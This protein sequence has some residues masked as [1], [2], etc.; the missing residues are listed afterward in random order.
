MNKS[1]PKELTDVIIT[2]F[3]KVYNE[4]GYG[5]WENVYKNALYFALTDEGVKCETEKPIK[6]YFENHVV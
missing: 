4:L 5:F 2:N 1:V 3:Y 6:V